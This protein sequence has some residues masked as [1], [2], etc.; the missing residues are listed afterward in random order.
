MTEYRPDIFTKSYIDSRNILA[1]CYR[2]L[3]KNI[4]K[5]INSYLIEYATGFALFEYTEYNINN[6]YRNKIIGHPIEPIIKIIS[7]FNKK[8]K[9]EEFNKI[10]NK[11]NNIPNHKK[12][13]I[14]DLLTYFINLDKNFINML[15]NFENFN[16]L[17]LYI[18]EKI[19]LN[20]ELEISTIKYIKI[21][22]NYINDNFI[23]IKETKFNS[24]YLNKNLNTFEEYIIQRSNFNEIIIN[25]I[26]GKNLCYIKQLI[27]NSYIIKFEINRY[28]YDTN[29]RELIFRKDRIKI[30]YIL[31]LPDFVFDNNEKQKYELIAVIMYDSNELR[32]SYIIKEDDNNYYH[33]LY[34]KIIKTDDKYFD[35]YTSYNAT[36]LFYRMI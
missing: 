27:I 6:I 19:E 15:F 20:I 29:I 32:Y 16:Y 10:L 35:K 1:L 4:S 3:K 9:N 11:I 30:P 17:F 21:K 14:E 18:N 33:Y 24:I 22:N 28:D 8:T 23:K 12:I 26:T 25:N 5:I 7:K 31:D 36:E 2:N 34:D 13:N